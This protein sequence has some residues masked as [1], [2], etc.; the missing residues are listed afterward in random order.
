MFDLFGRGYSSGPSPKAHRYDSGL[1]MSQILLC[2]Q[3]SAVS[4]SSFTIIGYSLGGAIAA[5]F[6]SYFPDLVEGL[7]LVASGGLIRTKHVSWKSR[8]LYSTAGLLPESWIESLV[9]RRLWTG[10]QTAR[11]IEPEPVVSASSNSNEAK[12][13]GL[14]SQAVY[15]SSNLGLLPGNVNST[16][17]NVV[18]WQI[19]HHK[20][21][22]PAFISSIRYAPIHNQHDRWRIIAENVKTKTGKL[23]EIWLV[24]GETDP[25]ILVDE[26]VEDSKAIFGEALNIKIVEAAGHE[27][28]VNRAS[29]IVEVFKIMQR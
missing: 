20:G 1:Y 14:R 16:V 5:D 2:L 18:D 19:S 13:G 9:M 29:E 23:R 22:I 27:V 24:L 17:S 26:M 28:A 25:I 10:P 4:W 21:F 8:L 15:T 11:T 7:V 3:S 6:A 12:A